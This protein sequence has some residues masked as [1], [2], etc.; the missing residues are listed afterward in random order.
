MKK[1]IFIGLGLVI[2]IAGIFGYQTYAKIFGPN[3]PV[4]LKD[5]ILYIPSGYSF[6]DVVEILAENGQIIDS[7]SFRM[8][9]EWM[10]YDKNRVPSGRYQINPSWSNRELI[11][12][13]RIGQQSPTQLV[14]TH[15]WL[16][17]DVAAKAALFIE[18][19]S[20]DLMNLLADESYLKEQGYT[21]ES[22]MSL[23]IPNTYQ[24][25]WDMDEKEFLD[26]MIKENDRFWESENRLAK[27]ASLG[28][29]PTEVY[30][31]ASI[32][33]REISKDAE[34]KRVAGL[35]LNRLKTG[36]KL[37][38]DPTAKFA[39]RDFS[40]TRILYK[41]IRYD[42][43][44][45][46]YLNK[47]LPPGPISM[48]SITSIDAVLNAENHDYYYMCVDPDNLGFHLFAES[49]TE[50]N[51]NARRYHL[52]LDAYEKQQTNTLN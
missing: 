21:S 37:D 24:V 20:A 52:W 6:D 40:A 26:R 2:L 48:A 18:P 8:V 1:K 35:Y 30:T 27:A 13:L 4:E 15:G 41:H 34:K 17:E 25:Y 51:Q 39:T 29:S 36:M 50:H 19:D 22:L 45:N 23:F 11:G 10:N 46:T 12:V 47:G 43:P 32:V 38:A 44:Y 5:N 31:L 3:V 33:E 14:L 9:A 42:S 16:V 49:L 7:S 28:L